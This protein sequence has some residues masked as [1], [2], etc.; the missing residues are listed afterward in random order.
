MRAPAAATRLTV[1]MGGRPK[2][3]ADRAVVSAPARAPPAMVAGIHA[4]AI[5]PPDS[6]K[7]RACAVP[8]TSPAAA[9]A[10]APLITAVA[11]VIGPLPAA[12]TNKPSTLGITT[13]TAINLAVTVAGTH[14]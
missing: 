6:L 9:S 13:I 1:A 10:D 3:C 4:Q 5:L 11:I 12:G 2:S 7:T 14:Q 8:M